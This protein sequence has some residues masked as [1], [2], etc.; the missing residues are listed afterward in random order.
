MFVVVDLEIMHIMNSLL[1][2]C[3]YSQLHVPA[4]VNTS[5][6]LQTT[7]VRTSCNFTLLLAIAYTQEVAIHDVH[8]DHICNSRKLT[9]IY[10]RN[11]LELCT[12]HIKR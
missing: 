2:I 10:G 7:F 5:R 4:L 9:R 1:V 8:I 11:I 12:I 6:K 3:L